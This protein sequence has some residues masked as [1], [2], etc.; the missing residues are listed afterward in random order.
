MFPHGARPAPGPRVTIENTCATKPMLVT[1]RPARP[2]S[3]AIDLRAGWGGFMICTI[4]PVHA[5]APRSSSAV[6][7]LEAARIVTLTASA[8]VG[9]AAARAPAN[10][11]LKHT[12]A[13]IKP[14]SAAWNPGRTHS[15]VER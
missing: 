10:S 14:A 9:A 2:N 5:P 1:T 7:S 11:I 3:A 4:L 6:R 15:R 8:A 12:R 13:A